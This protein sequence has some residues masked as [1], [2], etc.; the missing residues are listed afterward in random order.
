[1]LHLGIAWAAILAGLLAG[2]VIGLFFHR[3]EWLGGYASWRR[4]MVRLGHI[5][6]IGTG[7]LNIA[8]AVTISAAGLRE[9]PRLPSG[10]FI[11][12]T[13]SMPAVCYLAAWRKP[14]RHLFFIPVVSLIGGAAATLVQVVLA[15]GVP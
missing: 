2:T 14:L 9:V 11:L 1:M 6:L 10:L 13:V 7:L 15:S 8:F 3:E 12:G 5:A 4:R